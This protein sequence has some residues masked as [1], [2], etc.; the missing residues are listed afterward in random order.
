MDQTIVRP[1]QIISTRASLTDALKSYSTPYHEEQP[2][3]AKFLELLQ[4][5]RAF[6]RDHLPGHITGSAWIVDAQK[7]SVLLTHHAKL[8]KWLQPGGHA[9]GDENVFAVALREAQEETGLKNFKLLSPG[10]F[11]IDIHIIPARK[12]FPEHWHYD[13]RFLFEA[14]P[15]EALI[16]T[17]ESHDL[18]WVPLNKLSDYTTQDSMLRLQQKVVSN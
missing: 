3:A 6:H 10:I 16:I 18:Q 9:D 15:A 14:D 5:E 4:H 1:D 2:F 12:D 7:Q 13:V 17:E 8:N 11:D